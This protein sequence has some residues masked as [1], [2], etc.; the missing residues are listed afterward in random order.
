MKRLLIIFFIFITSLYLSSCLKEENKKYDTNYNQSK[1]IFNQT[2]KY[3]NYY[4]IKVKVCNLNKNYVAR[5][6]NYLISK[7]DYYQVLEDISNENKISLDALPLITK[8]DAIFSLFYVKVLEDDIQKFFEN[9]SYYLNQ[10]LSGNLTIF[11]YTLEELEKKNVCLKLND[12]AIEVLKKEIENYKKLKN[13]ENKT[14][15]ELKKGLLKSIKDTIY[16][17]EKVL[18]P[19]HIPKIV[20]YNWLAHHMDDLKDID[21]STVNEVKLKYLGNFTFLNVDNNSKIKLNSLKGA[22]LAEDLLING[23]Y[24][25]E[26]GTPLNMILNKIPKNVTLK[27]MY[28]SNDDKL[29]NIFCQIHLNNNYQNLLFNLI[30]RKNFCVDYN[31]L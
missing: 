5:I 2:P 19:L 16:F 9:N 1:K 11:H 3:I 6:D 10:V 17:Y 30:R 31:K 25:A 24:V 21:N 29:L 7:D 15:R 13:C 12:N 18:K 8:L 23:S 20:Y 4:G 22:C 26:K 27:I 14:C 28:L